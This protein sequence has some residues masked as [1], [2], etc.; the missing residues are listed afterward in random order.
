M[1]PEGVTGE[2]ARVRAT[3]DIVVDPA[4]VNDA[5]LAA[6]MGLVEQSLGGIA[7]VTSVRVEFIQPVEVDQRLL[8][9][10]SGFLT[11]EATGKSDQHINQVRKRLDTEGLFT[12]R[13]VLLIGKLGVFDISQI[14]LPAL[15]TIETALHQVDPALQWPDRA[16]PEFAAELYASVEEVP[17]LA[18]RMRRAEPGLQ[19]VGSVLSMEI[20]ELAQ[21]VGNKLEPTPTDILEAM[22][23]RRAALDFN[24]R[25]ELAQTRR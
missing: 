15:E 3:V 13:D 23:L 10:V 16:T 6:R 19:V 14:G 25:F 21:I 22:K 4:I 7:G 8:T 2:L 18:L 9:P 20:H 17:I 24:R 1:Y 11:T 5:E 12:L